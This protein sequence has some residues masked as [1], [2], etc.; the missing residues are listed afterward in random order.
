[1]P[2]FF[3]K[4]LRHRP[5]VG[6]ITQWWKKTLNLNPTTTSDR[7]FIRISRHTNCINSR[8]ITVPNMDP[9]Q[10][11]FKLRRLLVAH[12]TAVKHI[13]ALGGSKTYNR[14]E[15]ALMPYGTSFYSYLP[16]TL[17]TKYTVILMRICSVFRYQGQSTTRKDEKN[18][19]RN[20]HR[21]RRATYSTAL[22]LRR[23]EGDV[24]GIQATQVATSSILRQCH[25]CKCVPPKRIRKSSPTLCSKWM[26][27]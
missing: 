14:V 24:H 12:D 15:E 9:V 26:F 13:L 19:L 4:K 1:M 25:H 6:D 16:K 3:W 8:N 2:P 10:A 27:P 23:N 21:Q 7:H 5:H 22:C 18:F 11:A 17:F 20:P